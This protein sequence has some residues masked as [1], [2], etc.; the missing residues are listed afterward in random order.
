M[1]FLLEVDTENG[2]TSHIRRVV[3][4]IQRIGKS[5]SFKKEKLLNM[6]NSDSHKLCRTSL[7]REKI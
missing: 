2:L 5:M 6:L 4:K 1:A 7:I 3:K